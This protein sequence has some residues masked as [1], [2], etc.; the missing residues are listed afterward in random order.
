MLA[1]LGFSEVEIGEVTAAALGGEDNIEDIYPLSQVQEGM[2]FHH[3]LNERIDTYVLLTLFELSSSDQI[4]RFIDALQKVMDRYEILRTAIVWENVPRPVQV[5]YR[6]VCLPVERYSLEPM[7]DPVDQI[8]HRMRP[9]FQALNLRQAPLMRVQIFTN[10][11]GGSQF[12]LLQL[13]H[14]IC[15]HESW[16]VVVS[17]AMA[18]MENRE[19]KPV[20]VVKYR[21]YVVSELARPRLREAEEFFLQKLGTVEVVSAPFG[22]IDVH[23]DGSELS[24]QRA[25][26]DQSLARRAR[27]SAKQLGV[28]V[29]RLFHAAWAMIVAHTSGNDDV[30]FGTVL[31]VR[32]SGSHRQRGRGLF[33]NTLP[34]RV[35]LNNISARE[36]VELTDRELKALLSYQHAPLTLAQRSSGCSGSGPLFTAVLNYRYSV[37]HGVVDPKAGCPEGSWVARVLTHQYRTNYPVGMTID[38]LGEDFALIA[39]TD[40][41]I[42]PIRLVEYLHMALLSLVDAL[43]RMPQKRALDLE[44]LPRNERLRVLNNFNM[45]RTIHPGERLIHELFEERVRNNPDAIAVIYEGDARTY[46]QLNRAANQ[47]AGHLIGA[48]VRPEDLVGICVERSIELVVGL[49]GILKA[50]GAYVPLDPDY[51]TERLKYILEDASPRLLIT[52]SKLRKRFTQNS[53]PTILLDHDWNVIAEQSSENRDSVSLGLRPSHRAYVIYTSGSTGQPKGVMVEHRSVVNLWWGLKE[54]Y[55][56]SDECFSIA[57]N[58]SFTFD[59][60][61]KQFIQLLSGCTLVPVP[62]ECR[63]DVSKLGSFFEDNQIHGID[64]TPSQLKAWLSGGLFERKA[65]PLR[66]VLVGGENI[67]AELWGQLSRIPKIAFYNVYGPTECTVDATFGRIAS[68]GADP[69]IGRPMENKRIYIVDRAGRLVPIGVVGEMYI[70]GEGLAR[71]YLHRAALTA[72]RFIADPF[73][74]DPQARV[75]RTGDLARWCND[76]TVDYI[77]RNDQQVKV[78]GFRVELGEIEAHLLQHPDVKQ[79]AVLAHDDG[80][81]GTRLTAYIATDL[82]HR[83]T[84]GEWAEQVSADA[85]DQWK[86]V[87]DETYLSSVTGPSFVGWNSSYTGQPI[88][89]SE[90]QEWLTATVSRIIELRPKHVL[91]IGCGVGLVLQHVAP[92]CSSYVG[93]DFSRPALERLREWMGSRSEFANVE[94][95][96]RSATEIADLPPE[97]FD[98]VILNSVVQYFPSIE[99]LASV[100]QSV[101]RLI[102]PGGRIFIGDVRHLGLLHTFYSS[103]QLSKAAATV[104]VGQLRKRIARALSNEKELV[105]DP[106]FFRTLPGRIPRITAAEVQLKRGHAE[107]ELTRYRYDV[108][109]AVDSMPAKEGYEAVNWEQTLGSIPELE[110]AL[111]ERRWKAVQLQSVPNHR[112]ERELAA[113]EMI[114]VSDENAEAG[115]IRR[116]MQDRD[117]NSG[118]L[119]QM[120][121]LGATYDYSVMIDW[122]EADPLHCIQVKFLDLHRATTT[123]EVAEA[124]PRSM[125]SW[126]E[127]ANAPLQNSLRQQLIPGLRDFV[128]TRVP[129]Y[130]VP[131]AW[132]VLGQLPLTPNG[133]LDRRA[134]PLPQVRAED[135]GE[136]VPPRNNLEATLTEIWAQVLQIDRVGIKDNFFE[137]GGHSLLAMQVVVRVRSL[138]S[139]ELPMSMLFDYPTI[140]Q[141]STRVDQLRKERLLTDIAAGGEFDE[142]ITQV[143]DISDAEVQEMV[144]KLA[145]R[146]GS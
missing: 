68:D 78:R 33:V 80:Q 101:V 28:S 103:V 140:D 11:T 49:L 108:V 134:L 136:Y 8:R 15:D 73:T 47:L 127:Y 44:I 74:D 113:Q 114:E 10:E 117:F 104:K 105:I 50:G 106:A 60:S 4:G 59:A 138:L 111:R 92:R 16:D 88:P 65:C 84:P 22:L 54:L 31:G 42:E 17:E 25:L 91:E 7:R 72:D 143:A 45:P 56:Q 115:V 19:L 38:N 71:G 58:A 86:G 40:R 93:V 95:L 13:H 67:D 34:L 64:C 14:M 89:E 85:V 141:L 94:L 70:G 69:S 20:G 132:I 137:I 79:A 142:L 97:S 135:L 98:T 9:E 12:A 1:P 57:M 63:W 2:L 122:D 123:S 129:E 30:V 100:L 6:E 75:Y 23:G 130:M 53:L 144:R 102:R 39:Q 46:S 131:S 61:V 62:Q 99:Y 120:W 81:A 37:G 21:D 77:G 124:T 145:V 119:E 66:V 24:E 51:P 29:S 118:Y 128:K 36:L 3:L 76:G 26:L 112:L 18:I 87:H 41:R 121:E 109:L 133:K 35:R 110:S 82:Q 55:R 126:S 5:V 83:T 139:I 52:Q 27:H 32:G 43:E 90:M 96:C 48:G 116:R 107:N 125:R 146:E